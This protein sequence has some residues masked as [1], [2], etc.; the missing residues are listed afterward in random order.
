MIIIKIDSA[1]QIQINRLHREK[2]YDKKNG[3]ILRII[4][5]NEMTKQDAE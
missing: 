4:M 3:E 1:S 5:G 2:K